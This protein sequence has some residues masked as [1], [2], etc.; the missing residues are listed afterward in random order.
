[1]ADDEGCLQLADW[2]LASQSVYLVVQ[3][4]S[5]E[6]SFLVGITR[7][8]KIITLHAHSHQSI[9]STLHQISLCLTFQYISCP[10][11]QTTGHCPGIYVHPHLRPLQHKVDDQE[12][13]SSIGKICT[14][15]SLSRSLTNV[16]IIFSLRDIP[17]QLICKQTWDYAHQCMVTRISPYGHKYELREEH[18]CICRGGMGLWTTCSHSL[19]MPSG[20]FWSWSQ[21]YHCPLTRCCCWAPLTLRLH[22][23]DGRNL[24]HLCSLIYL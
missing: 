9:H 1:M 11:S 7:D 18:P 21:M 10:D 2:Q 15:W 13:S 6:G 3:S 16:A 12:R 14:L 22:G 4:L 8:T 5:H 20:S 19:F 23:F 17:S 24:S